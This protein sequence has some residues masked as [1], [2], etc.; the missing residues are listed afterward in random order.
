MV[1]RRP[2]LASKSD[3]LV[4]YVFDVFMVGIALVFVVYAG[5]ESGRMNLDEPL[6]YAA[7]FFTYHLCFLHWNGGTSFGKSLRS[8]CVIGANGTPLSFVQALARAAVPSLPFALFSAREPL[9]ALLSTFPVS[10]YLAT[11]P[12][13][14]WWLAE[15][16]FV[17]SGHGP[18]SLTDRI[19]K[20]IVVNI[21]PP[22]PHR[23]PAVPMYSATDAEFGPRPKRDTDH[24]G[25]QNR[26]A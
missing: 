4:A 11:L 13:V 19:T 15:I 18:L 24:N 2:E 6:V 10:R 8:S 16:G 25:T 5:S 14:F 7:I 1:S 17:E 26:A 9:A 22:Q 12:G 21:P 3:L 20:T 23:A